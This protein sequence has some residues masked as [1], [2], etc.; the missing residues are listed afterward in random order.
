VLREL[1]RGGMGVVFLAERVDGGF[2]QRVALKLVRQGLDGAASV[3]RFAAERQILARLQHEHIARLL[4]GGVSDAGQPYFAMELVEGIPLTLYCEGRGAGTTARLRL[5]LQVCDAV[6]YAHRNLVVHR[7][8]KPSNVL[9]TAE[10]RV[11][12]LD[13]GI[14]KVLQESPQAG[15]SVTRGEARALTP[16]YA[17]PE[18]L[19][20]QPVT[21][22]TDVYSLGV[23]LYELLSGRPPYRLEGLTPAEVERTVAERDAPPC[24][25]AAGGTRARELRGDLDTIVAVALR[26]EPGRRYP[27]VRALADDLGRYRDGRPVAARGD[28]WTYRASKFVGR[29]RVGVA[30]S[31]LVSLT[32]V[33]GVLTTLW[34][35]R[36][37]LRQARRAEEVKRF[38]FSLFELSD[39]DAAKGKEVTARELL[40]RGAQRV[41]TE[42]A[43]Q[44]D[45]QS[46]MLLFLGSIHHRLGLDAAARPLREKALA[47]RREG[48]RP[49]PLAIAEADLAVGASHMILG[50]EARAE[51]HLQRA[52]DTRRRRLGEDHLQTALARGLLGQ[53]LFQK[54]DAARAEPLLRRAVDTLRRHL[55]A[56]AADLAINLTALG[57]VRQDAGDLAE[58]EGLYR[59]GLDLRRRVFGEEHT[60]VASSLFNLAA[61]MKDRGNLAGAEAQYR[62]VL[63]LHRRL[64]ASDHEALA[65]D[66]NNLGTT[67]LA[68]GRLAEADAL[69]QESLDLRVRVHGPDSPRVAL[70]LHSLAQVRRWQGRLPEA[71]ALSRQALRHVVGLGE[72][73]RHVAPVREE[74]AQTLREQGRLEEAEALA[75]RALSA[76]RQRPE[77]DPARVATSLVILGRILLAGGRAAEAEGHFQ[78]AV[79]LR[80]TKLGDTDWRT[81][82][83]R[84]RLG[85]CLE[86]LGRGGEAATLLAPSHAALTAALG[87]DHPLSARAGAALARVKGPFGS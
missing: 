53:S 15:P 10:G 13:F 44:P 43:G 76:Y 25:S 85:E 51:E 46:E 31:A 24:S 65:A 29:H 67:L 72:D 54:D 87:R 30:A 71:E 17:A 33:A 52:L 19:R 9:V 84:F 7:D 47:L 11:R 69:L 63:D 16:Q 62:Q 21:T 48:P 28:R 4:D 34:Q 45:L 83:A 18:Q 3:A 49:D 75:G 79:R 38:T 22:A 60:Q 82:E 14:A 58:A 20:G 80:A 23:V 40:E 42:L 68:L 57:V 55:P 56:A 41:E 2:Q 73:H 36:E 50:D 70:G 77:P 61:V 78:E 64:K 32:L 66:L 26:K 59:E 6:D 12:L 8:L 86:A 5:F 1:G 39:P 35:A 81:A 74:L 37:A 27:S